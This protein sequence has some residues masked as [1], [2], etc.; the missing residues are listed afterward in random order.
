[1]TRAAG[2]VVAVASLCALVV[3]AGC[4]GGGTATGGGP[5]VPGSTCIDFV[6]AAAAPVPGTVVLQKNAAASSCNLVAVDLVIQNVADLHATAFRLRYR[7]AASTLVGYLPHELRDE[8]VLDA[9]GTSVVVQQ[10]ETA[11]G[12]L[13]IGITRQ[14][15]N[16]CTGSNGVTVGATPRILARLLFTQ[17]GFATAGT[18]ALTFESPGPELRDS[19]CPPQLIT[20]PAWQA[21]TLVIG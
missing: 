17:T 21:G 7:S 11:P 2:G 4:G 10:V 14:P 16:P 12:I 6:P 1:V 18:S 15:G 3:T 19:Q 9:D 8:T 13:D 5:V 20:A